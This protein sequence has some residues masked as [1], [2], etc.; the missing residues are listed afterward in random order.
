[1]RSAEEG[2]DDLELIHR[3]LGGEEKAFEILMEKYHP[4]VAR[5]AF[6]ILA[7][8]AAAEDIA[9]EVF[10]RAY[11]GLARF[12]GEASV[13]SWLYRITVNLCLN[14]LHRQAAQTLPDKDLD[15]HPPPPDASIQLEAK[16]RDVLVRRALDSLSPHYRIAVILNSVEGLTYQEI[17]NLLRIPMGTVKSRINFGKR[18]LKERILPLLENSS[19]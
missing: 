7:N 5:L 4:R 9:Q 17:S 1:M 12:R 10:V 16:Q 13:F 2:D 14:F 19:P 11:Q 15:L 6:Q 18:L 3:F 8:R